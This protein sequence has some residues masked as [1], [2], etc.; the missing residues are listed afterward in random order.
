MSLRFKA[1]EMA[2]AEGDTCGMLW[3]V[4][5]SFELI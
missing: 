4:P 5:K 3:I 2:V 1:T